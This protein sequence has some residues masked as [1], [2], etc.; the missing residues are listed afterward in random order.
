MLRKLRALRPDYALVAI[1]NASRSGA[2]ETRDAVLTWGGERVAVIRVYQS[3][4]MD[5]TTGGAD[6]L[7]DEA[8]RVAL[9]AD[10][11]GPTIEI[12]AMPPRPAR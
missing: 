9:L 10:G 3:A 8:L 5:G 11:F 12:Y 4:D 6:Q 2:D 7:G 1:P